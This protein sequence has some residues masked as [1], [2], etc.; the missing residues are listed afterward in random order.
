[1]VNRRS[2]LANGF[3]AAA[4]LQGFGTPGASSAEFYVAPGGLDRNPGNKSKPF[5]TFERARDEV[6]KLIGNGLKTNVKVWIHGGTYTSQETL[7]FGLEDSGT[8]PYSI[9]YQA[10][11]G[12]RSILSSGV[13]IESGKELD[14]DLNGSS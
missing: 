4:A 1:M 10:V 13:K 11:P 9:T 8:D 3:A 12:G 7:M 5:A 6:C 2:F 14:T